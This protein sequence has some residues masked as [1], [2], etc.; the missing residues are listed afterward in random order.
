MK[1]NENNTLRPGRRGFARIRLIHLLVIWAVIT[2]L[3][4]GMKTIATNTSDKA[5]S[6]QKEMTERALRCAALAEQMQ[7]GSDTLTNAIWRFVAMNDRIYAEAYLQEM[8]VTR[9]RDS[10]IEALR[11]EN[12]SDEELL[13]MEEAKKASDGL[14]DQEL[15]AMRLVYDT[16]NVQELPEAVAAVELTSQDQAMTSAQKRDTARAFVF[17]AGYA[18]A[19]AVITNKIGLFTELLN[20]HMESDL[21]GAMEATDSAMLMQQLSDILLMGWCL[22]FLIMLYWL[23]IRP[24]YAC[25]LELEASPAGG[26]KLEPRGT[27]ELYSLIGAFNKAIGQIQDKNQEIA[28]ILMV[29]PVTGGYTQMRLELELAQ[30]LHDAVPFAFVSMDIRRFKVIND[31]YGSDS[32]NEV[33]QG[34]YKVISK[35]LKAGESVSRIQS[36]IFNVVLLDTEEA[37]IERRIG[38][39]WELLGSYQDDKQ[40]YYL[41]MNCGVYVAQKGERDIIAIRDRANS[42][43]K[44]H[45]AQSELLSVCV[46]YREVERQRLLKEQAMENEMRS[47]LEHEEFLVYFQPKVRLLDERIVGAEA[48]VRWNSPKLGWLSPNAIIPLFEKNGFITMLDYYVFRQVCRQLRRWLDDGRSVVPVSVNLSRVHLAE[49]GFISKF[50]AIQ[51]EYAIDDK[52]LE[53]ELTEELA[54][55]DLGRLRS[56]IDSLHA[57]GYPCSMDDFGSGYSSLN[58]LKELPLDI[59]KLDRVFFS[60][61]EDERGSNVIRAVVR[62][63]GELGMKVVAEGVEDKKTARFLRNLGCDMVQGYVYYKP[64]P[65]EEFEQ[66]FR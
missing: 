26:K 14:M 6:Y 42:A 8:S 13:L 38:E 5:L 43:R 58:V 21:S 66:L 62:M 2:L 54:F 39:M 24:M 53:F 28:E 40:S 60:G 33:L 30:L 47:A 22:L 32:G 64:M 1:R 23:L 20:E 51:K 50:K 49:D 56:T 55:E 11:R 57:A 27:Y 12:L 63:A 48:L 65:A 31:L 18:Q 16:L 35:K 4:I 9:S 59:L 41:S 46:F 15:Y 10:A 7:K 44:V 36:D 25:S 34:V 61:D 17:G 37:E 3:I 29:D 52:Y 45:K 19:K